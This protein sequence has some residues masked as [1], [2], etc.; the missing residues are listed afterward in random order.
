MS[1]NI[2]AR[3]LGSLLSFEVGEKPFALQ[4]TRVPAMILNFTSEKQL[5]QLRNSKKCYN[6][7]R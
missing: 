4:K 2:L 3:L 5:T 6:V 7:Q 1:K